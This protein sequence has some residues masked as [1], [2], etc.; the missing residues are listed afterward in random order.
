L[1]FLEEQNRLLQDRVR[2]LEGRLRS[3]NPAQSMS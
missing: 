1:T 2:E 3:Q